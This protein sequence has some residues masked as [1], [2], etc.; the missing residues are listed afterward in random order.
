MGHSAYNDFFF[1]FPHVNDFH[2]LDKPFF[3]HNISTVIKISFGL[4]QTSAAD[5]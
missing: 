1:W 3:G 5:T 2:H 4:I